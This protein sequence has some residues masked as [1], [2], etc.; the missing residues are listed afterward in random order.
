KANQP[1]LALV[2]SVGFLFGKWILLKIFV[3]QDLQNAP[4]PTAGKL[5]GVGT[6]TFA[7]G[8]LPRAWALQRFRPATYRALLARSS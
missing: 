3:Q 5:N 8:S 7:P 2:V 4:P 6:G 1:R